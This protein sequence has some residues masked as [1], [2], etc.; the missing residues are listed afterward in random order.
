MARPRHVA[1][2]PGQESVW[3]YP[4][5]PRVEPATRLVTVEHGGVQIARSSHA[6]RVLETAGAP[7]YYIPAKDVSLEHL[8]PSRGR[9]TWCEWKGVAS[10]FDIVSGE[11]VA[12]RAAWTYHDPTPRF[13][14]L[15]E[16]YAFYPAKVTCYLDGELVTPQ[17]GGFYGGWVTTDIV[18]PFKGEPGTEGW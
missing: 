14:Q 4:R 18:G 7:A 6:L 13:R 12:D 5:P 10:Y 9:T 2:G 1:P 11:L 3:D 17:P 16:H 8:N 15:R